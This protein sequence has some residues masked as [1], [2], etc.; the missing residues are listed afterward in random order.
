MFDEIL[1]EEIMQ[2]FRRTCFADVRVY[3]DS[4]GSEPL[5]LIAHKETESLV[6]VGIRE[7]WERLVTSGVVH[8]SVID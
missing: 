5:T 1:F 8:D 2:G 6:L 7:Y 4:G 3:S